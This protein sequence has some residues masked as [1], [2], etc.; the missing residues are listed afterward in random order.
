V[1]LYLH[2]GAFCLGH[3]GTHRAI[4]TR[5]AVAADVPVYVPD[6]RLAPEHPY[7][8]ALDDAQAC[9]RGLLAQGY[10]PAQIVLAG[11]SAGGAL[12]LAL[13]WR[14]KQQQQPPAAGLLL[15]SPVTDPTLGGSTLHSHARRD[16][17]LRQSWVR[18]GMRWYAAPAHEPAHSPLEHDLAGLPP[19][20]IQV[21]EREILLADATRLAAHA[22]RCGVPCQL[23]IHAERW[24]VFQLQAFQLPSAA[25]AIRS[26]G[27]FARARF[28]AATG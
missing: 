4:S 1:I 23:E 7:P 19:M 10:R 16:P 11:D 17:M 12:A 9:Y 21:G 15:L 20:F 22:E 13:A 28:A 14:L 18:Q 26:L 27:A 8:A 25:R 5:L 6:Y 2:G 3:P 24:H